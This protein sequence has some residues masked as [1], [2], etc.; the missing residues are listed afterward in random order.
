MSGIEPVRWGFSI[1]AGREVGRAAGGGRA[2]EAAGVGVEREDRDQRDGRPKLTRGRSE[3]KTCTKAHEH[4]HEKFQYLTLNLHISRL[5]TI[6][7]QAFQNIT[8]RLR[9]ILI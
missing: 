4:N 6:N 5:L 3:K 1:L 7:S 2:R 8:L 9:I